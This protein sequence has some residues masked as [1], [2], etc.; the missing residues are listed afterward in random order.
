MFL[1]IF[2][3]TFLLWLTNAKPLLSAGIRVLVV[4]R[5]ITRD[6]ILTSAKTNLI[7]V[8]NLPRDNRG[9][10]EGEGTAQDTRPCV[11]CLCVSC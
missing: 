9:R 5:Y 11:L 1:I 6:A 10:R 2:H 7:D 8:R 3:L 4:G